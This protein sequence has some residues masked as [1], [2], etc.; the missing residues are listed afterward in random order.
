MR[1]YREEYVLVPF[2]TS[3]CTLKSFWHIFA[4]FGAAQLGE[5]NQGPSSLRTIARQTSANI[6]DGDTNRPIVP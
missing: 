3:I 4:A 2:A 6:V 1:I 5:L